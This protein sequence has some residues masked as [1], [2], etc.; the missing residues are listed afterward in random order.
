MFR[1]TLERQARKQLVVDAARRV[2]A[3]RGV[4]ETSMDHI[5]AAAEYTRRTVYT[6]F[7]NRD[8]ICLMA[9]LDDLDRCWRFQKAAMESGQTGL[10]Q[11]RTWGESYYV[12]ARKNPNSLMLQRYWT[13][14]GIDRA[15][16]GSGLFGRLEKLNDEIVNHLRQVFR[17]G[18]SDHSLRSGL[19]IDMCLSQYLSSLRSII[20]RALAP[21]YI[22]AAFDPDRY[23]HHYLDLFLSGL[24]RSGESKS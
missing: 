18:I 7:A 13:N 23:V 20:D 14:Q 22:F 21:T 9:H 10:D 12:F 3:E 16:T 4:E 11:I 24:A 17:Q 2:F 8:E 15:R 19:H 1:K 5:A 6:Y